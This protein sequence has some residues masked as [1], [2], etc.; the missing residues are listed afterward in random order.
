MASRP[1]IKRVLV[2][3][4]SGYIGSHMTVLL[5][6]KGYEPVVFDRV[7]SKTLQKVSN[8]ST[9]KG[10]L[11]RY[12][13]IQGALQKIQPDVVM[14]FAGLIV[15][16]ESNIKP[17]DYLDH[18]VLGAV[19]L[20]KAM[21]ETGVKKIIFSSTAAVYGNPPK[22][23][24]TEEAPLKPINTY[25][26]TKLMFEQMLERVALSDPEFSYVALRYFN[27]AGAHHSGLLGERH[28]PETHLIPNVLRTIKGSLKELIVYGDD[29][30]TKDGTCIRDYVH[31]E[32]LTEAHWLAIQA[33]RKGLSNQIIN[34]GTGKGYSAREIITMAEKVTGGKVNLKVSSR[35]PGDPA[36]LVAS[37]KKAQK[38]LGWQPQRSLTQIIESAWAW[39]KGLS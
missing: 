9:I 37:Y 15:A 17:H 24:I 5:K 2:V 18:N 3:G 27:A 31:V 33:L 21:H 25:G 1:K 32:D 7:I 38:L 16:P 19:N 28:N 35:R 29:Y 12:Q 8:V 4:G 20:L 36:V 23:P 14:Y 10:D 26:H 6:H 13:D 11:R 30:P 22:V 39:E 34:L